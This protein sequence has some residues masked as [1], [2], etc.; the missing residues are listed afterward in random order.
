MSELIEF[1]DFAK[2][3]MSIGTIIS[4]EPNTKARKPAYVMQ[5][6]FGQHGIK[7][8]SAQITDHYNAEE[9][10]GQQVVAVMN[11]PAKRIAGIKSEVLVLGCLE[12]SG[13]VLLQP[14]KKVKNGCDIA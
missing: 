1:N 7:T 2:V 9:L 3:K 14:N 10:I 6:D 13:V 4:A 11:F 5:V 8:T 12:A